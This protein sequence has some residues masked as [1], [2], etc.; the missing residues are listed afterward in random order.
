[1]NALDAAGE[2]EDRREVAHDRGDR[3][4]QGDVWRSSARL[5]SEPAPAYIAAY[6]AK[7]STK[8]TR[9]ASEEARATGRRATA[10]RRAS[11]PRICVAELA[12]TRA[13]PRARAAS[14]SVTC[15]RPASPMPRILP[16]TSWRRG[17]GGDQQLHDPARLLRHDAGGDP[18]PV[19]HEGQE[20][21]HDEHDADDPPARVLGG[22]DRPAAA[23][24]RGDGDDA[25]TTRTT[26]GR[27]GCSRRAGP[28]S[29]RGCP[30][31]NAPICSS[32][33]PVRAQAAG[34]QHL[35]V[36]A[37]VGLPVDEDGAGEHTV[38]DLVGRRGRV[39]AR[40]E[41]ELPHARIPAR[42]RR[43]ERAVHD[44]HGPRGQRRVVGDDANLRHG[45]PI[46]EPDA[47]R[48]QRDH[49]GQARS[50][51]ASR[52]RMPATARARCTHAGR[53]ARRWCRSSSRA[54][55][56]AARRHGVRAAGHAASSAA[57][58]GDV[59]AG[60][61]APRRRLSPSTGARW[62]SSS[63]GWPT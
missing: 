48:D 55:P 45:R 11:V 38:A 44:R 5:S 19:E 8:Y 4:R 39:R 1:M 32:W 31:P 7:P 36:E 14:T 30:T 51:A 41:V 59:A 33:A 35:E 56:R 3:Q 27:T 53:R 23:P 47:K 12:P 20:R 6:S 15:V 63:G 26:A 18:Q 61:S 57:A 42:E 21:E 24:C 13:A 37:V 62:V 34:G 54:W 43:V 46:E 58:A 9:N 22:V 16:T 60:A 50:A 52:T 25:S 28:R 17:R 40:L 29:S 2:R 49:H 10:R